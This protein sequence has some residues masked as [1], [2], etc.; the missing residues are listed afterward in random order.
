VFQFQRL[1]DT[2]LCPHRRPHPWFVCRPLLI[3]PK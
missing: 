2:L 1:D 3:R